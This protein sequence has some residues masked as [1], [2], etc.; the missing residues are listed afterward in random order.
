[1]LITQGQDQNTLQSREQGQTLQGQNQ[2]H[3]LW[4]CVTAKSNIRE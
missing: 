2:G 1:M 3:R 4:I